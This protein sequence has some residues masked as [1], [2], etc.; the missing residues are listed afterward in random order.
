M[1]YEKGT[2][3]FR[4]LGDELDFVYCL[5]VEEGDK[6]PSI[7]VK[8]IKSTT[9]L[10]GFRQHIFGEKLL[11]KQ[12]YDSRGRMY[13]KIEMPDRSEDPKSA[14]LC[15]RALGKNNIEI[16]LPS[17]TF[18]GSFNFEPKPLPVSIQMGGT[19]LQNCCVNSLHKMNRAING[20]SQLD[21]I[22]LV[23]D[24]AGIVDSAEGVA[25]ALNSLTQKYGSRKGISP[26][27][28]MTPAVKKVILQIALMEQSDHLGDRKQR[29]FWEGVQKAWGEYRR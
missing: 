28:Q 10:P 6:F 26:G 24:F 11:T 25:K 15:I 13:G 27:T 1:A 5:I 16:L 22:A 20:T 21:F 23:S 14:I 3:Y 4:K 19:T 2:Y 7:K 8:Y 29:L 18:V 17:G 9:G 12:R